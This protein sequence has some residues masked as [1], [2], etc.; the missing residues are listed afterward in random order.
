MSTVQETPH[1]RWSGLVTRL[2]QLNFE[3]VL[4]TLVDNGPSTAS[5]IAQLTTMSLPTANRLLQELLTGEV[6]TELQGRYGRRGPRARVYSLRLERL[7]VAAVVHQPGSLTVIRS[8]PRAFEPP[9][10]VPQD[11]RP[12]PARMAEVLREAEILP[13]EVTCL[14]T[15]TVWDGDQ[16]P[17]DQASRLEADLSSRLGC[18][19]VARSTVNLAAVAEA[20]LGLAR[21]VEE[22][23]LVTGD[24]MALVVG[25]E[26]R[27]GA[28]GAAGS[29][30]ALGDSVLDRIGEPGAVPAIVATCLVTDP[31]LV[32]LGEGG[33]Q[34]CAS[35][36]DLRTALAGVMA[37]APRVAESRLGRLAPALGAVEVAR[38]LAFA[39]LLATASSP[40]G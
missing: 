6:V 12:G 40:R 33:E 1:R 22:F 16:A 13:G 36:D 5:E 15:G 8:G 14:V 29:L 35:V 30:L 18:P 21:G 7:T 9:V 10:T 38:E 26:P 19:V 3:A 32:V 23:L 4:G 24:G 31:E 25:G 17:A 37:T 34:A 27:P 28:H 11:G 20:R 2:R 39:A